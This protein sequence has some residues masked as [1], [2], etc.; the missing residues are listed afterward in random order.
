MG[1]DAVGLGKVAIV[2]AGCIG[3]YLGGF[4]LRSGLNVSFL[5]RESELGRRLYKEVCSDGLK[6]MN[7]HP[8]Q[9]RMNQG[10]VSLTAKEC[11]EAFTFDESVALKGASVVILSTKRG[12]QSA[13]AV[14]R[15]LDLYAP[16]EA[17][18]VTLQNGLGAARELLQLMSVSRPVIESVVNISVIPDGAGTFVQCSPVSFILLDAQ[19]HPQVAGQ[20]ASALSHAGIPARC[21]ADMAPLQAGKLLMNLVNV[22]N[23]LGGGSLLDFGFS[24]G[25][26]RVFHLSLV[27]ALEVFK[28][29]KL[30]PKPALYSWLPT[31]LSVLHHCDPVLKV[32]RFLAEKLL[33][34]KLNQTSHTS[35]WSDLNLGRTTEIDYLNGFISKMG[36]EHGVPT[37]INDALVSL[38]KKAEET[39]SGVPKL[40]M[41]E[42]SRALKCPIP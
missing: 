2:G 17:A 33:G 32:A 13:G 25:L 16:R 30:E 20:V 7:R 11:L 22:P 23:A 8:E 39:K 27:E 5:I 9:R 12:P 10:L 4:L 37:P 3:A 26:R 36:V 31:I 14:A 24:K 21:P 42:F 1:K 15:A 38:V 6:L 29:A 41:E 19:A 34:Y 28:A 40:S 35:M 18:V